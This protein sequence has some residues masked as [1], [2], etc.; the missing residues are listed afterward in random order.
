MQLQWL[1]SDE[2]KNFLHPLIAEYPDFAL[3]GYNLFIHN[4]LLYLI[5]LLYKIK[6]K[7]REVMRDILVT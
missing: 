4:V 7:C 5:I 1:V 2:Q 6:R 3:F